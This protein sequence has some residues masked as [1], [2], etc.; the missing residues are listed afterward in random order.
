M[1]WMAAKDCWIVYR[2]V[3]SQQAAIVVY[4]YRATAIDIGML[5]T[6]GSRVWVELNVPANRWQIALTQNLTGVPGWRS[7]YSVFGFDFGL[8]WQS[9][10]N[11]NFRFSF[12]IEFWQV[13][14]QLLDYRYFWFSKYTVALHTISHTHTAEHSLTHKHTRTYSQTFRFLILNFNFTFFAC[15]LPYFLRFWGPRVSISWRKLAEKLLE[16]GFRFFGLIWQQ[17]GLIE[18]ALAPG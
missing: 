16:C 6:T 1:G 15:F 10:T 18:V 13:T 9:N 12:L 4:R 14:P 3:V 5:S 11:Q 17:K 8:L 7:V 2:K